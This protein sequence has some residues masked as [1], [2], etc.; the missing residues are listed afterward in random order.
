[1]WF[2]VVMAN[3]IGITTMFIRRKLFETARS[4]FRFTN[5]WI[6]FSVCHAW[7]WIFNFPVKGQLEI[8]KLTLDRKSNITA[9]FYLKGSKIY[10]FRSI[11]YIQLNSFYMWTVAV[12]GKC[13]IYK[14]FA[15]RN[16]LG[17][18]GF[19]I[20]SFFARIVAHTS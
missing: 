10:T 4:T 20:S 8:F 1:M 18:L 12:I 5:F 16:I 11:L 17:A 9:S 15:D 7:I 3:S 14:I 19:F 13:N 6:F 2:G